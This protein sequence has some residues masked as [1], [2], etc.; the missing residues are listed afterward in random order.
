MRTLVGAAQPDEAARQ[1]TP[2]WSGTYG[3]I[4]VHTPVQPPPPGQSTTRALIGWSTGA[5]DDVLWSTSF[6]PVSYSPFYP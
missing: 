5:N 6:T 4:W 1:Q 3:G 2:V